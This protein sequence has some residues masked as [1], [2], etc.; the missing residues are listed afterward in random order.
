MPQITEV[1]G[2]SREIA[3]LPWAVTYFFLIGLS[4]G[5]FLLSLP[6]YLFGRPGWERAGRLALIGALACGMAAPVALLADLHQPG[7][8]W[9]FYAHPNL[10]SWMAWGA[11]FIPTYLSGLFLYAWSSLRPAIAADAE[12]RGILAPLYRLFGGRA[13]PWLS[14]AAATVA[15]I[16]ACLVLLYTGMEVMVVRARPLWNTPFLPVQFALTAIGGAIGLALL[17]DRLLGGHEAATEARLNRALAMVLGASMLVGAAWFA[18]GFFGL[19][20]RHAQALASVAQHDSFRI[21]AFEGQAALALAILLA[22][23]KPR[24]SGWLTG[25]I[26]LHAA[27]MFRWTVFI[28]GQSVPKNAPGLYDYHLPLG[29]SGLLGI[30]GSMGLLVFLIILLDALMPPART[31]AAAPGEALPGR[32]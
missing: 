9:R 30:A 28:G 26:A 23:W 4:V 7:R 32:A 6:H 8:F 21:T 20:A 24:G 25:L 22:L 18:I 14:R 10:N 19:E 1:I 3:W 29:P 2:I 17:L 31:R 11:F 27:W 12:D 5:S 15:I 13:L 16:G